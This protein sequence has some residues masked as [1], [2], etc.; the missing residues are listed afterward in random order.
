MNRE[1]KFR[2]WDKLEKRFIYSSTPNQGHYII[3]LNGVFHNLQNGSGGDDY[4]IQQYTGLKDK[5]NADIYEGDIVELIYAAQCGVNHPPESLGRYAVIWDERRGYRL[6][7]IIKNWYDSEVVT[8]AEAKR[9]TIDPLCPVMVF[10][11]RD[12][13]QICRVIG[14]IY[15]NSE[16]LKS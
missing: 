8:E 6:R 9:Q 4:V 12:I 16:L 11:K 10:L 3:T 15:E 2:V 5:N 7:V 1:I 13:P 14:N